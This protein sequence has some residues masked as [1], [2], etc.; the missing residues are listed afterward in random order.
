MASAAPNPTGSA[1]DRSGSLAGRLGF[2]E[3]ASLRREYKL[4]G[5]GRRRRVREI[6]RIARKQHL[7]R[8]Q[9]TPQKFRRMLEELGPTFVKMGQILSMRSEILPQRYCNELI[10]LRSEVEP[11][12]FETVRA[13][14]EREYGRPVGELFLELDPHPL[15]SASLAQVH[16]AVLLDGTVL[17]LKVQRPG[18][19]ETMAQDI[20]ILR[21]M[22]K[23]L[24]FL[25]RQ[26]QIIDMSRVVEELW[27][28]FREEVDFLAEAQHLIEFHRRNQTCVYIDCPS[29]YLELCTE[30]ILAMNFV[31]GIPISQTAR[32]EEAGYDLKEIGEKLVDNYAT[33]VLDHGYFHADPHPGN[34]VILDGKIIYL[35]LGMMGRLSTYNRICMSDIIEAVGD[36]SSSKLKDALLRFAISK[37]LAIIDHPQFLQDLD[38]IVAQY[39]TVSLNEL[40]L[41]ALLFSLIALARKNQ[42]ELPSAVTMMARGMVTLEGVLDEFL[43]ATNM[44][45]IIKDHIKRQV[46][47]EDFIRSEARSFVMGSQEAAHSLLQAAQDMQELTHMMTRGQLKMNMEMQMS[48]PLAHT[49]ARFVDR[50]ALAVIIAGLFVGSSIVYYAGIKPVIFGIPVLGFLGYAGAAILSVYVVLDMLRKPK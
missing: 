33:Q 32:L 28:S 50:M 6:L 44:I 40:D 8:G 25:M 2:G 21:T 3:D 9:M 46:D 18:V 43:P 38:F 17:A 7:F 34:L 5:A 31:D 35:D 4:T 1:P 29:P 45:E 39:G 13:T 22:V 12:P 30:H 10:A 37:N 27:V 19:Q 36:A 11:M 15:G 14:V 48:R 23:R 41:G 16:R 49:M 42:V 26:D 47:V 20:D 24:R